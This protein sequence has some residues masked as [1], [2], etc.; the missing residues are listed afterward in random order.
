MNDPLKTDGQVAAKRG[1]D[2]DSL[3]LKA[4]LRFPNAG[5]EREVRI[6]NLSAGGLMAEV[7][8]RVVRGE[9]VEINLRS[10]GWISGHVAWVTEGRLGIAFDHPINPK[11]AR[12]P[13]GTV[14]LEIPPY[15][16]KLNNPAAPSKLRRL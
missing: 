3:L 13:V 8:V 9:P 7:P 11:D 4:V 16:K 14:E 2:R 5:E 1:M 15:L 12:K 6:R 10:I